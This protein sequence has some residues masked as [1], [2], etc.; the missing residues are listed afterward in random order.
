MTSQRG[1]ACSLAWL[2]FVR[3]YSKPTAGVTWC[4]EAL[5]KR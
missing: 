5:A 1:A 2:A 4:L 3:T